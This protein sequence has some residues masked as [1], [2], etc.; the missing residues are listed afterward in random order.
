MD[1]RKKV[2]DLYKKTMQGGSGRGKTEDGFTPVNITALRGAAGGK[3]LAVRGE[4]AD[5]GEPSLGETAS[6][7]S[8]L[9]S[10]A[11]SAAPGFLKLT[12]KKE[13]SVRKAAKFLMLIGRDEAAGVMR[14]FTPEEAEAV[15]REIAGI[16]RIENTEAEK[17]LGE[18][19][20][21]REALKTPVG[22]V[23]AAR[24][25]LVGAFGEERGREILF[26]SIP[27]DTEKFFSFLE[28]FQPQQ[29]QLLFRKEPPEVLAIVMP[30]LDA[31][32]A[33][34]LLPLLGKTYRR[35]L[36]QRM[37]KTE[38]I[39]RDVLVRMEDALR[40]R[41]R[42]LSAPALEE[43]MDGKGALAEI[44]KYVDI[45]E[46]EEILK[47]IGED[48]PVIAG[49]IKERLFTIDVLDYMEDTDLQKVLRDMGDGEIAL[50]LKGK[51]D[52]IR[53]KILMNVSGRRRGFVAG[54][55]RLLGA[56]PRKEVDAATRDFLNLLRRLQD[57]GDVVFRRENDVWV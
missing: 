35:D 38:K 26:R 42:K 41:A 4:M 56:V 24:S 2:S 55:Y 11:S 6:G 17:I 27:A 7:E 20:L 54:E 44:L 33:S 40:E 16:H 52:S 12:G 30:Y 32:A 3:A 36:I 18:F 43:E 39:S 57:A 1:R 50:L 47:N 22:G 46:E 28:G 48:N 37:A 21:L 51:S 45:H 49:E 53:A 8:A 23:E 31:Q 14:H 10:A 29:L 9:K 5:A 25:I 19:G 34:K 15:A 13:T